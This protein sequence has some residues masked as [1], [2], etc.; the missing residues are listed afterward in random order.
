MINAH[1]FM[2]RLLAVT[3]LLVPFGA[4]QAT[5]EEGV[6]PVYA[7]QGKV[8]EKRSKH[9]LVDDVLLRLSP[10]V[11]VKVRGKPKASLGDI[12]LGSVDWTFVDPKVGVRQLLS[13]GLSLYASVGRAQRE[14]ARLDLLLGEDNAT[15]AHDLEAVKPESV[16]DF[17]AGVN[18]NSP[19]L[20]LQANVYTMEFRDEIA[21]TGELSEIGLPLRRNVDRSFRRGFELDLKWM[22]IPN[23]SL[24]HSMNLSYNRIGEWTQFYDVYDE[25]GAWI[26]SGPIAY[27]DVPPL[28]TP[29]AIV[30]VG[31]EYA[32]PNTEVALLGRYVAHSQLDNTGLEAF[33]TPAFTTLD[34]RASQ[35]LGRWWPGAEPRV[36]LF[37]NN[38]LNND[39]ALP[40]GY[41]YQFLNRAADGADTL[42]GIPF[43][44]P[45]ATFNAVVMLELGF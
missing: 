35:S 27:F 34:V 14:P 41:S 22:P 38:L 40:S 2:I 24:L 19:R 26:G 4:V 3:L 28:L 45:L 37:I 44:Y 29:A 8:L 32:R 39:S 9:I 21:L 25:Q 7:L 5:T 13:P 16:M 18:F 30:N 36:R 6:G 43:Y 1:R 10:T 31:V 42:D 17:E 15:I 23:W 12:D 33:R 20:A 11:K